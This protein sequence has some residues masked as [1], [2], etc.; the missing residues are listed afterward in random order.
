MLKRAFAA[1]A[2]A[3]FCL[4]SPVMAQ[5]TPQ[6]FQA[7][8][9]GWVVQSNASLG[10]GHGD[11][12]NFD[13]DGP[14]VKVW[15]VSHPNGL[16]VPAVWTNPGF[17]PDTGTPGHPSYT[18]TGRHLGQVF[19]LALDRNPDG[20]YI[21][22]AET[23]IYGGWYNTDPA[24]AAAYSNNPVLE[25]SPSGGVTPSP[26]F[27]GLGNLSNPS[28]YTSSP[29]NQTP[30]LGLFAFPALLPH[31]V[32]QHAGAIWRLS[33]KADLSSSYDPNRTYELVAQIPTNDMSLGQISYNADDNLFYVSNFADGL[34]YVFH[35]TPIGAP[36]VTSGFVTYDHGAAYNIV[37][38]HGRGQFTAYGRRIWGLQYNA[39]E[40]R[41][42]YAVWN[43]DYRHRTMDAN[44]YPVH[45]TIYS[46]NLDTAGYPVAGTAMPQID[47][48]VYPFAL[49]TVQSGA[50]LPPNSSPLYCGSNNYSTT[51]PTYACYSQPVSDIAFDATDDV[52]LL[53][54]RGERIGGL[55]GGG[56]DVS[57]AG[58]GILPHSS[59]ILRYKKGASGEWSLDTSRYGQ[60]S[61]DANDDYV[62][63]T[64][65]N[66]QRTDSSGGVDFG[67]G[68]TT[69]TGIAPQTLDTAQPDAWVWNGSNSF[70]TLGL[71]NA[72]CQYSSNPGPLCPRVYGLMG[73]R[74]SS[75][76]TNGGYGSIRQ[77]AVPVYFIDFD[78][79][80][81]LTPKTALGDVEVNRPVAQAPL[82]DGMLKICKVAGPGVKTGQT[83]TFRVGDNKNLIP[84]PGG[85]RPDGWCKPAGAYPGGSTQ[86]VTETPQPPFGVADIHVEPESALVGVPDLAHGSADVTIVPGGVTEVTF[87]N[88]TERKTI[89]YLEVCKAG[90]VDSLFDFNIDGY[91]AVTVPAGACSPPLM[92]AAG[93][94]TITE[95]TQGFTLS[96]CDALP[97]GRQGTCDLARLTSTVTVVPGDPSTQTIATL[98][99]TKCVSNGPRLPCVNRPLQEGTGHITWV[100]PPAPTDNGTP[101]GGDT[102]KPADPLKTPEKPKD[103]SAKPQ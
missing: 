99:N 48:P 31:S 78:G 59:R 98:T 91:G 76:P 44:G 77:P 19:G 101:R 15:D 72:T 84:V 94:V 60:Y 45:N 41:L 49:Q 27:P 54:E 37:D 73:G 102:A 62:P 55:I 30:P 23:A 2:A 47:I 10:S 33:L 39:R 38:S 87:T 6:D 79:N 26:C 57:P 95:T 25:C 68:Y 56:Y 13:P 5:V 36:P 1:I 85:P 29:F 97:A 32:D 90:A 17:T 66:G 20:P 34:I 64:D 70:R 22:A 83:F 51:D 88:T 14:V 35:N 75:L 92:V 93:Q 67:Y 89:G 21:Y 103:K 96:T 82:P 42:Y 52:M 12:L 74:I 61:G 63:S 50:V 80:L 40:R 46:V 3:F 65:V 53:A 81:S 43:S 8:T 71:N 16:S 9:P 4:S 69:G 28:T 24:H 100:D 11:Y 18:W 58:N 7:S 86:H